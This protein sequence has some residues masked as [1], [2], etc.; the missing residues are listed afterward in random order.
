VIEAIN[1]EILREHLP[2][3]LDM[4]DGATEYFQS[5]EFAAAAHSQENWFKRNAA[6]EAFWTHARNLVEFLKRSCAA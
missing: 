3:E 1:I 4:F 2:Y 6:V 5:P